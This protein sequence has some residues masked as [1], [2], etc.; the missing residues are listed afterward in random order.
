LLS[1]VSRAASGTDRPLAVDV[2]EWAY[3][4]EL[5]RKR[6]APIKVATFVV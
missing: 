2:P 1:A 6:T 5:E 3:A 4:L